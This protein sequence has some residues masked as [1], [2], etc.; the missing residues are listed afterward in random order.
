M[1]A[2]ANTAV[3]KHRRDRPG[4]VDRQ[5]VAAHIIDGRAERPQGAHVIGR[6]SV[7]FR[8]RENARR[9]R[10]IRFVLRMAESGHRTSRRAIL[11]RDD[12]GFFPHVTRLHEPREEQ[13]AA[14]DRSNEYAANAEKPGSHRT[15]HRFGRA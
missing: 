15:L 1:G 2:K 8:D 3:A 4:R 5:V 7:L 9:A 10:V 13:S 11:V 12:A 14:L 6:D